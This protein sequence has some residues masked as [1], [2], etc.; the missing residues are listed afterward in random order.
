MVYILVSHGVHTTTSKLI[1]VSK[2]LFYKSLPKTHLESM[3]VTLFDYK[4]LWCLFGT[5]VIWC[6]LNILRGLLKSI[7]RVTVSAGSSKY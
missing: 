5:F 4:M 2:R 7:D 3:E 1:I 6:L